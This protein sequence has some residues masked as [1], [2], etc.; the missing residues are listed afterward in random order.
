[1]FYYDKLPNGAPDVAGGARTLL[2][3]VGASD[4]VQHPLTGFLYIV[5]YAYKRTLRM[6]NGDV[7][8]VEPT[9]KPV[10]TCC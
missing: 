1:V 8:R 7:N 9:P 3:N 2:A 6:Y 5:D 10:S 4:F